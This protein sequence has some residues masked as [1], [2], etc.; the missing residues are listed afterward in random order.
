[1]HRHDSG[2]LKRTFNH[3][4]ADKNGAIDR[5]EFAKFLAALDPLITEEE[6]DIGFQ[7]IDSDSSGAID[8]EEFITWWR[9]R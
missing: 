3:Y 8:F 7:I 5:Q 1:M 6:A 4:D 2:E 9:E